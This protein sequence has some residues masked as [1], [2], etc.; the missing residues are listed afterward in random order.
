M[1]V[2]SDC[3]HTSLQRACSESTW[4]IHTSPISWHIILHQAHYF[5]PALDI[6]K[7]IF[8]AWFLRIKARPDLQY[9][10][11]TKSS[12]PLSSTSKPLFSNNNHYAAEGSLHYSADAGK[13]H[14]MLKLFKAA[15]KAIL[16]LLSAVNTYYLSMQVF[17]I[18]LSKPLFENKQGSWEISEF[19]HV[20]I[21]PP[22]LLPY[23]LL[24]DHSYTCASTHF[25]LSSALMPAMEGSGCGLSVAST[26][27][28]LSLGTAAMMRGQSVMNS[29]TRSIVQ[30]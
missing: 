2:V 20:R 9:H 12:L 24:F 7:N 10:P 16:P 21:L 1:G 27:M 4:L 6:D 22:L 18:A 26:T 5:T 15:C 11:A 19:S 30:H 28:G 13:L 14:P 23:F 8:N 3:P 25:F 29:A 17:V